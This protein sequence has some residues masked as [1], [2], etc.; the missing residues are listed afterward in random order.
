MSV[1]TLAEQFT[2]NFVGIMPATGSWP[3]GTTSTK[4]GA[5]QNYG[6]GSSD[7]FGTLRNFIARFMI[8]NRTG[9]TVYIPRNQ[10]EG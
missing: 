8:T 1:K 9:Q 10:F 4:I 2:I 5:L 6:N 3:D 7:D